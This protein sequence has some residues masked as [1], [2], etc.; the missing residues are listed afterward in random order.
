MSMEKKIFR[1]SI[2]YI[3]RTYHICITSVALRSLYGVDKPLLWSIVPVPVEFA[4]SQFCLSS[5][6]TALMQ[7]QK[8]NLRYTVCYAHT[9]DGSVTDKLPRTTVGGLSREGPYPRTYVD[10]LGVFTGEFV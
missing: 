1:S 7:V 9:I 3:V 8:I 2:T 4:T 10:S 5:L 6:A